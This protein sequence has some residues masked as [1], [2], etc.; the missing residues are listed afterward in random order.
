[1]TASGRVWS[2][3]ASTETK[4]EQLHKDLEDLYRLRGD[5]QART[6]ERL[7]SHDKELADLAQRL[8]SRLA[9][10]QERQEEAERRAT[11]TDARALPVVGVGVV[12]SSVPGV[13]AWLPLWVLFPVLAVI[14]GAALTVAYVAWQ[15][16]TP[17][18][19][20]MG[21]RSSDSLE[22]RDGV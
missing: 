16:R 9:D 1:M 14:V 8:E 3:D 6:A 19:E 15:A 18:P 21:T 7:G 11:E 2:P 10:V 17:L 13:L 4:V 12:L 20:E 5:D 22:Q